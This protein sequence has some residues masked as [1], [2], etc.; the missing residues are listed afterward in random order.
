[1]RENQEG[2]PKREDRRGGGEGSWLPTF[3]RKRE[4]RGRDGEGKIG[5]GTRKRELGGTG[6]RE[7][8]ERTGK[9]GLGEGRGRGDDNY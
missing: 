1:M 7:D 6:K 9:R 2:T 3:P 8:R 5:R 4:D